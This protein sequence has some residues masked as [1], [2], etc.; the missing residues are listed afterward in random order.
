MAGKRRDRPDPAALFD[1]AVTVGPSERAMRATIAE[2][3]RAGRKIDPSMSSELRTAARAVDLARS[4]GSWAIA[5]ALRV[6]VAARSAYGL[7]GAGDDGDPFD[8]FLRKM[9]GD[10]VDQVAGADPAGA[11]VRDRP[12]G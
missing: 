11:E 3:R 5:N 9:T 1:V 8:E 10:D 4:E 2:L 12:A 6:V 7:T